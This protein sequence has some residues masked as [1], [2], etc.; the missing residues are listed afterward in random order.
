MN[1]LYRS[2][3]V[4]RWHQN[5]EMA[6]TGQTLGHHQWGC[7]MLLAQ[8][9]PGPS[10]A[11]LLATLMHDVGEYATGDMSYTAK[12][13]HVELAVALAKVEHAEA[14]R[15]TEHSFVL[16]NEDR[17]WLRL[18]DRLESYLFVKTREP[19]LLDQPDWIECR[20]IVM[21]LAHQ[22]GVGDVVWGWV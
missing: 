6:H 16:T 13:K 2:G 3:F 4:Q 11:L 21:R 14:E 19:R 22:L 8:L 10:T 9:H 7:A 15:I 18:V 17:R 20:E 12:Q 1:A 5:P